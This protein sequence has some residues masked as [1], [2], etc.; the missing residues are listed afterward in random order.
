M[1]EAE[2]RDVARRCHR[3]LDP[4][5]SLTYFAPE[6]EQAL[7]EAGLRPGRMGY[8]ASRSAPMGRVG[9][10]VVTATFYNFSPALVARHIPRAWTLASIEDI[11]AARLAAADAAT[12]RLLSE[13][14]DSPEM[15]EAA[16]LARTA[17][18]ACT[19]EGRP[20]Y[21]GHAELPW[22][23][24]PHLVLWH[25]ITLLRE[26]RGDGHIAA[27]VG[28]GLNGLDA[29]LTHTATGRGFLPEAAQKLRGWSDEEWN[30]ALDRLREQ[31]ILT[32][33]N[34]LTERGEALRARVEDATNAAA[35]GPWLALGAES[36]AR[37]YELGRAFSRQITAAGAFPD[38]LFAAGKAK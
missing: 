16:T 3:V 6:T 13:A 15:K 7:T 17:S 14:V 26:H 35:T 30:A 38:G 11:L 1:D 34:E 33:D 20:L 18:E 19:P 10:N 29:L 2:I 12:R 36:A 27:L 23:D 37:L 5:H 22:P 31:E 9:P 28:A 24:E 32:E 25:A 4:L 21:A 8:F